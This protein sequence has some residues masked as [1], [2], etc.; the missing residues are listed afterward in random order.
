LAASTDHSSPS[1]AVSGS[2]VSTSVWAWSAIRIT[3]WASRKSFMPPASSTISPKLRS[4]WEIELSIAS[5]PWV[6][7]W[8][9]LSG[10]EKRRKS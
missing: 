6:W 5:T 3:A 10:S 8:W 7:V 2:G 9:S 4:A 1:A